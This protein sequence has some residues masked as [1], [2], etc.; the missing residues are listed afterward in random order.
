MWYYG[1]GHLWSWDTAGSGQR[2]GL[3]PASLVHLIQR[4]FMTHKKRIMD[5]RC[6]V[7][8]GI[9]GLGEDVTRREG[10]PIPASILGDHKETESGEGSGWSLGSQLTA[11]TWFPHQSH[12]DAKDK[13]GEGPTLRPLQVGQ[14]QLNTIMARKQGTKASLRGAAPL[15]VGR[16]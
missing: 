3:N 5:V 6:A 11:P 13:G 12:L 4:Q 1:W 14:G 10:A 9:W 8:L 16:H 7:G 15:A 2:G